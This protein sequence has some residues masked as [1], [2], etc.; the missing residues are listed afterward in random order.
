MIE[1]Y[2]RL[3]FNIDAHLSGYV[4][5]YFGP[6][7]W[8][9][10]AQAE[11]R[12]DL[13]QLDQRFRALVAE[14]KAQEWPEDRRAYLD[15]QIGA[16]QT[17]IRLLQ[18][19]SQSLVEEVEGLYGI[20]PLRMNES[21]FDEAHQALEA[22]LPPG[23]SLAERMDARRRRLSVPLETVRPMLD[24]IL[25]ELR[26]RTQALFPL[27]EGESFE[28]ALVKD[29]PWGAYNWYLGNYRSRIDV[30]TDLPLHVGGLASLMAHEGYPGHHTE[31]AL[32]EAGLVNAQG[33]LK[34][35]LAILNSPE[36]VVA[37]GISTRALQIVT[38]AED[39]REWKA[40]LIEQAEL[41]PDD[42]DQEAEIA[43]ALVKLGRIGRNVAF[44]LY[45]DGRS[46]DEAVAYLQRYRLSSAAAAR[47]S[48]QF[49]T[50]PLFRTYTFTYRHGGLLLDQL[51]KAK[52][53]AQTW[54]GRLLREP[55]TPAQIRSWI[56]S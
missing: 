8:K 3:A 47:K 22:A 40:R 17:S 53:D 45:E 32:K 26:Q 44:L 54:F 55:V 16:M 10:A 33:R 52:G 42:P 36:Q 28:M 1:A 19:E 49:I 39:R 34:H 18:G 11:G 38:T 48:L 9:R 14:F 23:G 5:A 50:H 27:P 4:D 31:G 25:Q 35:T 30:N 43:S 15:N 21:N 20:T 37:E 2:I 46:E 29:K 51:F 13:K 24:E 12:V 7:D 6:D 56:E 41:E